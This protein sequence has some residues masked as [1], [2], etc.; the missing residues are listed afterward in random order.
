MYSKWIGTLAAALALAGCE[1]VVP[2]AM[3]AVLTD[4][5]IGQKTAQYFGTT[6]NLVQVYGFQR[7]SVSTSYGASYNGARYQCSIHSNVV[8][9][10]QLAG[11]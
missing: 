3:N 10:E 1:A 11:S 5:A 2:G 4:E 9:C 6:D 7:G 8:R